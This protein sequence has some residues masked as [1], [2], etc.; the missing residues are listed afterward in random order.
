VR[1]PGTSSLIR[2]LTW[3]SALVLV[4]GVIAFVTVRL[5]RE[6]AAQGSSQQSTE[7]LP[8]GSSF[9]PSPPKPTRPVPAAARKVAGEFILAAVGREDLKK[10]WTITHPELKRQCDCTYKQWLTG[11]I[12]I[13]YF[14]TA[15]LQ[16]ASFDV[17]E[18]EP[19]HVV[20][21]V[22][23]VPPSGAVEGAQAFYIGLKA[24]GK[25]KSLHWLVDYWA[26]AGA[27]PVPAA[28]P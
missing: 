14:K 4:A 27:P 8:E 10:A 21:T 7:P 1:K 25:G 13:V 16:G 23:L 18:S 24:V 2:A 19:R 3:V 17:E 15:G 9:D 6:D 20:L 12:P 22:G 26:P 11:N 28:G 5:G